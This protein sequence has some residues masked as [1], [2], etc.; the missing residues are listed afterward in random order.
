M[1][2]TVPNQNS[3]DFQTE[4]DTSYIEEMNSSLIEN[5]NSESDQNNSESSPFCFQQLKNRSENSSRR[6]FS[7]NRDDNTRNAHDTHRLTDN[8]N[9]F[10]DNL[11][12]SIENEYSSS[13]I[14]SDHN[15]YEN[16][17][18]DPKSFFDDIS[19]QLD[20]LV[21]MITK[22]DSNDG[23]DFRQKLY[24]AQSTITQFLSLRDVIKEEQL[25]DLQISNL[26]AKSNKIKKREKKLAQNREEI[27]RITNELENLKEQKYNLIKETDSIRSENQNLYAIPILSRPVIPSQRRSPYL[28]EV[29]KIR[30]LK[31][32][33]ER[34]EKMLDYQ[35]HEMDREI[36]I[37]KN[38]VSS[39]ESEVLNL[40]DQIT[41]AESRNIVV[42]FPCSVFSNSNNF[43]NPNTNT[44]SSLSSTP[45]VYSIPN[46]QNAVKVVKPRK[47]AQVAAQTQRTQEKSKSK[48]KTVSTRRYHDKGKN[49]HHNKKK[50]YLAVHEPSASISDSSPRSP[51]TLN[52]HKKNVYFSNTEPAPSNN[53]N[54][55][56]DEKLQ[57]ESDIK[58]EMKLHDQPES[59]EESF[60]KAPAIDE[61]FNETKSG[62]QNDLDNSTNQEG[63]PTFNSSSNNNSSGQEGFPS[64]K[65]NSNNNSSGQEGFPSF[66][67]NPNNNSSGQEGFPTFNS[68]SNANSANQEGFPSINSNPDNK[69]RFPT[70][71]SDNQTSSDASTKEG[72]P[73]MNDSQSDKKEGSDEK[74]AP[75]SSDNSKPSGIHITFSKDV[76]KRVETK[77]KREKEQLE[78]YIKIADK[79]ADEVIVAAIEEQKQRGDK[80][81]EEDEFA[82]YNQPK[83]EEEDEFAIYN[84]PPEVEKDEYAIYNQPPEVE[85]DEYAIYNKP[86]EVEKDEYA[87][88]NQRTEEDENEEEIDNNT[89]E[90]VQNNAQ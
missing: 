50:D 57:S 31:N 65:P 44:N 25:V 4:M 27:K 6:N 61:G 62:I 85:K 79:F 67:P 81:Q 5:N 33:I 59:G 29:N 3:Q 21:Q 12:H 30:E 7:N 37:L 18:I 36:A 70:L 9:L 1:N 10:R 82:I 40:L 73:G 35:K 11:K 69:V 84:Q 48:K 49:T 8:N 56:I 64:F 38:H 88:Y 51:R 13:E 43:S 78:H 80:G 86:P 34:R 72:F 74:E 41:K 39:K 28:R 68:D 46:N 60:D 54:D 26:T 22:E 76:M 47:L 83:E 53:I 17:Y 77:K 90:E 42:Y 14:L 16:S 45:K 63:F 19:H 75:P 20:S 52:K 32:D 15:P 71:N 58:P 24:Y 23:D 87:I 55:D 2:S 66:K 89:N